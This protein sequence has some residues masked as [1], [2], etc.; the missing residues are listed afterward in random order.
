VLTQYPIASYSTVRAEP[1]VQPL[2]FW[3]VRFSALLVSFK[4]SIIAQYLD[5]FAET[6]VSLRFPV[7][8]PGIWDCCIFA[9]CESGDRKN[10]SALMD[11][12]GGRSGRTYRTRGNCRLSMRQPRHRDLAPIDISHEMVRKTIT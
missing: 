3:K 7:I 5:L 1:G 12:E 9:H 4:L 11:L 2:C 10:S 8:I 6:Y